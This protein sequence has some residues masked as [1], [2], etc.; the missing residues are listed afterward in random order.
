[1]QDDNNEMQSL[2]QY[3]CTV[4]KYKSGKE[5]SKTVITQND[6]GSRELR[7]LY[8]ELN[9][10]I[11]RLGDK[12]GKPRRESTNVSTMFPD[13]KTWRMWFQLGKY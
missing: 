3:P 5:I 2:Y 12:E 1:M 6:R 4:T 7:S 13:P 10:V 9:K 8:P 11:K